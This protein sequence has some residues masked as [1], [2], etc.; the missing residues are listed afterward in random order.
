[1]W[2][3]VVVLMSGRTAPVVHLLLLKELLNLG[4]TGGDVTGAG[5]GHA[6]ELVAGSHRCIHVMI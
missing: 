4:I 5:I 2:V 6:A 3:D 1:M